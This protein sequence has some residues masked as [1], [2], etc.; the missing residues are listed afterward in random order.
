MKEEMKEENYFYKE[1]RHGTISRS[2]VLLGRVKIDKAEASF[3][4]GHSIP[5]SETIPKRVGSSR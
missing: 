5:K 2:I 3:D 1:Y 4:D